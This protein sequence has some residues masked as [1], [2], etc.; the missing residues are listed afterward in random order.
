MVLHRSWRAAGRSLFMAFAVACLAS[1][2]GGGGGDESPPVQTFTGNWSLSLTVDGQGTP[3]VAVPA[4][5]VPTEQQASQVTTANIA[6]MFANHVFSGYTVTV[7][8]T[9]ATVTGTNTSYQLTVNSISATNYQ[10]CGACATGSK[11]SY[12]VNM[13][14][15][16]TGMFDGQLVPTATGDI[17]VNFAYTRTS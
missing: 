11:V 12:D 3:G 6:Q 10:G 8:G 4:S 15:T 5:A 2:G 9:R 17:K 13:N 1:C 16:E 7:N 14:Y